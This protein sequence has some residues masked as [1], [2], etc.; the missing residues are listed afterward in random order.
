MLTSFKEGV[1]FAWRGLN[2]VQLLS[3]EMRLTVK[4]SAFFVLF[5]MATSVARAVSAEVVTF[6]FTAER[7][8]TVGGPL[9]AGSLAEIANG[10]PVISGSFS[11]DL[12][13]IDTNSDPMRGQYDTGSIKVNEFSLG[14]MGR[15]GV[16][17][18]NDFFAR[19]PLTISI[20]TSEHEVFI[21]LVDLMAT[22]FDSDAL[23]AAL[24]LESF[25]GIAEIGFFDASVGGTVYFD[26]TSLT[27]RSAPS[28]CAVT[29]ECVKETQTEIAGF[30][31]ARA[32]HVI[33]TQPDLARL[34]SANA[35]GALYADVTE[36][37][38]TFKFVTPNR[39]SVWAQLQGSWSESRDAAN[40]Y[41][42]GV[43]GA[44]VELI[45]NTVVGVML[46]FDQLIRQ[47]GESTT[48][49]DGYLVGPYFV[50]KLPNQPL[51][52][53]GRYLTGRTANRVN[54]NGAAD[55]HFETDRSLASIKFAGQL[56]YDD[57]TITP[58]LSAT[59]LEDT[60]SDFTNNRGSAV[61]EQGITVTD[62]AAG[63]NF[64]QLTS[65]GNSHV[66]LSGGFM[67][68]WSETEG[69]GVAASLTPNPIGS[70]G[71]AHLGATY[72][73]DQGVVWHVS[74][75]YDGIGADGYQSVGLNFGI[76]VQ[77]P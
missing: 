32:E 3:S 12:S 47:S 61:A 26:L 29:G 65:I 21:N 18:A 25:A 59:R 35:A 44:S 20:R 31:R 2:S 41:I 72:T 74:T 1:E 28:T 71:R 16:S 75:S 73:S 14:A 77:L 70:R 68:V 39:Q 7:G 6:S 22:A 27:T 58:N 33:S 17:L 15:P 76:Q 45:P 24:E 69:S 30:L 51:Y 9:S 67:S 34:L 10:F 19:D 48:E 64:T 11:H 66:V 55:Q 4:I 56:S 50:T 54:V 13:A 53:E 23:P 36:G 49:G 57:L 37:Q 60:Q 52:F 43:V 63:L 46:Q 8:R 5:L 42:F 40:S 38:G 62:V